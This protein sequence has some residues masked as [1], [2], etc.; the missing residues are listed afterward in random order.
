NKAAILDFQWDSPWYSISGGAGCPNDLDLY[1]LDATGTQVLA[2][3][4]HDNIG[5]DPHES[6]FYL[7][8]TGQSEILNVMITT[9]TPNNLPGLIKYVNL[10]QVDS[11]T[12]LEYATHSST[13]YGHANA[14]GAFTLGAAYYTQTPGYGVD[15]A[16]LTSYSGAGGTPILFD[17]QG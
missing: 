13:I 5:Q 16:I 10:S 17:I 8:G 9:T 3:A 11:M 4:T 2:A 12:G 1:I 7:N 15:P 14:A 6:L